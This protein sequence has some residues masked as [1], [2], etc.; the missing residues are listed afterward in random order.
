M[1]D[2]PLRIA[3]RRTAEGLLAMLPAEAVYFSSSSFQ[4]VSE[5]APTH[6]QWMLNHTLAHVMSWPT[7][8]T[9]RWIGFVQGVMACSH[10]LD[11]N[12]ERDRTRPFFHAAYD[13]MGIVKPK[14]ADPS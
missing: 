2:L 10:L 13:A 12:A 14:T 9:S 6:L 1:Q 3:L 5:A 7:D 4:D 11:C 8:K